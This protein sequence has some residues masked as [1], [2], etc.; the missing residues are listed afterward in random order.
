MSEYEAHLARF[1]D[2][3]AEIASVLSAEQ[4]RQW[5]LEDL[6]DQAMLAQAAGEAGFVVDDT[7]LDERIAK[8]Y[9]DI[10]GEAALQKWL[11]TY[12]YTDASFRRDLA[13]AL[14]AA[15][16]RDQIAGAISETTEQVHVR[17]IL[18]YNLE[19]ANEVLSQLQAGTDF[20]QLAR[21]YDPQGLGDLGW[22]PRGYLTEP[23]IEAAAFTLEPG[24]ISSIIETRMGFHLIQ[25][26]EKRSDR[27]LDSDAHLALQTTALQLWMQERRNQIDI[28]VFIFEPP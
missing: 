15:W 5:V 6:I 25:V 22:F 1:T 2:A 4:A 24:E 28:E 3:Q 11:T 7:L 8:L 19:N 13:Q 18:L 21:I 9:T 12:H 26:L 23:N 14:A 27:P 20:S 10:G 16:M 17:Q